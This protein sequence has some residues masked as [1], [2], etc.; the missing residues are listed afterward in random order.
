[1]SE[2]ETTGS[3]VVEVKPA[4]SKTLITKEMAERIEES[5]R[6]AIEDVKGKQKK[7]AFHGG[8]DNE[9]ELNKAEAKKEAAEF[10]Q[11][12][13]RGDSEKATAI[14]DKRAK[15]LNYGNRDFIEQHIATKTIDIAGSAGSDYLVP[16][17]FET[18]I[19]E[20]FDTYDEI[21]SDADVQSFNR[22]GH[23][24]DLN[25]LSTRIVVWPS[26][27]DSAGTTASQP[28]YTQPQ[29]A[30][31]DW[32]G[33][34]DITLDFLEDTEVD[35][36]ADLSRQFGEEMAKK[37]QARLVNGDVTISGVVTKG[38][39]NTSGLNEV[40]IANTTGGFS[41]IVAND[42]ENAYF[43][44]IS[45][46]HFQNENRN[47]TWYMNGVTL[48]NLRKNIRAGSTLNDV[49]SIFDPVAMTLM[50]RPL[51]VSNQMPT[52]TTT[53]SDPFVVYG[54][55]RNH[56]KIRRKRGITMKVN[57]QG[58]SKSGRNLNYQLGRE[59]V[60]T[61]RIGHAVVLAEGLTIIST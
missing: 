51:K 37:F 38:I 42:I 39:T 25:E 30:I 48:Y 28:T 12:V 54:N 52:P 14:S 60:V 8:S 58:T 40:L 34:T 35:I 59:L 56:L 47:G 24:F 43:D 15:A 53:T 1:M 22:P 16:T 45:I 21:I 50:G 61:Q 20:T 10:I 17:V 44:A 49:I 26:D 11:A 41:S 3:E 2:P 46:D 23:I 18:Q 27:E 5:V 33:S 36:M 4:E 57:D 55:L 6:K 7:F 19:L 9:A 31:G 32:F 13:A 29:I